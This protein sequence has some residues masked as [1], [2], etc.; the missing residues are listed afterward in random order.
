MVAREDS[1]SPFKRGRRLRQGEG[2]SSGRRLSQ[3][4][5]A[6]HGGWGRHWKRG[7]GYTGWL[8]VGSGGRGPEASAR[9]QSWRPGPWRI[10][11]QVHSASS[12][13][14][15]CITKFRLAGG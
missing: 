7:A 10:G 6:V 14:V 2:T 3:G 12:A 1:Y 8:G 4:L 13:L 5:A 9:E 15:V 11:A